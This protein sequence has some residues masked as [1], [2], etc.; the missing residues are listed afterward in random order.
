VLT[1]EERELLEQLTDDGFPLRV[2][3]SRDEAQRAQLQRTAMSLLRNGLIEVYGRPDD[4]SALPQAEAE[5]I[6]SA[7]ESWDVDDHTTGIWFI[8]A[9]PAGKRL[10]QV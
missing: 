4:A 10:L 6:L 2:L 9:S 7:P 5:A 8:S 3:E 1:S